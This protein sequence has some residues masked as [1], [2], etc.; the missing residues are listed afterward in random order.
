MA[1]HSASYSIAGF[2]A[3]LYTLS[4]NFVGMFLSHITAVVSVLSSHLKCFLPMKK[5]TCPRTFQH[6]KLASKSVKIYCQNS[7]HCML[8][9]DVLCNDHVFSGAMMEKEVK[10]FLGLTR[11]KFVPLHSCNVANEFLCYTNY[12]STRL[13]GHVRDQ[14]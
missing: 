11:C 9:D 5:M 7:Q 4:F 14:S 10:K 1:Q 6:K 8:S 12:S 2:I 3:V 13:D